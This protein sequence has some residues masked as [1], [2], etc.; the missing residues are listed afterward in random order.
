MTSVFSKNAYFGESQARKV[1]LRH[2]YLHLRQDNRNNSSENQK[3]LVVSL[4]ITKHGN[5]CASSVLCSGGVEGRRF[6]SAP[7]LSLLQSTSE[8]RT[9]PAVLLRSSYLLTALFHCGTWASVTQHWRSGILS[10]RILF[11]LTI[12]FFFCNTFFSVIIFWKFK[13]WI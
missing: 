9:M 13:Y 3:G 2:H 4:R 1:V 7:N 11:Y 10:N 12:W 6:L 5:V 8:C